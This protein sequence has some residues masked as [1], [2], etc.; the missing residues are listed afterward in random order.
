MQHTP[1]QTS[2][3]R[4]HHGEETRRELRYVI[5]EDHLMFMQMLTGMLQAQIGTRPVAAVTNVRDGIA[6]CREH[7]PDLLVL[8][9]ALPDA[10]GI[11]V[12]KS[13]IEFSP[14][15]KVIILSGEASSFVVPAGLEESVIAIIDKTAAYDSL[16]DHIRAFC[17]TR[18]KGFGPQEE[19]APKFWNLSQREI[20]VFQEI[21]RG[22]SN[23]DI[24]VKLGISVAT[25]ETHRKR[26]ISKTQVRGADLVRVAALSMHQDSRPE[27]APA[28]D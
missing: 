9:L 20:E 18:L 5:V 13:L 10:R 7:L 19:L 22:C 14:R 28:D 4:A 26:I 15:S 1:F 23:K 25:V 17:E 21:G 3:I 12:A 6:A 27:T 8:D 2:S 16:A 24:A 11:D